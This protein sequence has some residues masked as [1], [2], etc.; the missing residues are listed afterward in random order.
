MSAQ[1][2]YIIGNGF[3]L[4]HKIPS[5]YM[6]FKSFVKVENPTVHDHV[7]EYLP[8]GDNWNDLESAF[9]DT[10]IYSICQYAAEFIPSYAD[11][12]WSD[13]GHHDYQFEVNRIVK[14]LSVE[15]RQIFA[16]W[17]RQIP[18]PTA[19]EAP[20]KL[21]C[22]RRD[23][24]YLS[25]NYTPTLHKVYGIPADQVLYIH[26]KAQEPT[27]DL[28]LGHSWSEAERPPLYDETDEDQDHRIIEGYELL[29][30]YFRQTFKPSQQI[31]E[32]H[33]AFFN[34]LSTIKEVVVLGHSLSRVDAAY[35]Q[36]ILGGLAGRE[37]RWTVAYEPEYNTIEQLSEALGLYGVNPEKAHFKL[38]S[39]L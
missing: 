3:D 15:L 39:E 16:Q 30:T 33:A 5:K 37:A 31:I 24:L 14:S 29:A 10:D 27:D 23:A 36:A 4:H 13:A 11:E 18:I 9:A 25:F 2:L 12:D 22:L 19:A 8:A 26:G 32:S 1:R 34:G 7:V 38:W 28:V 17:V 35:F 20:Y 6:D 21:H